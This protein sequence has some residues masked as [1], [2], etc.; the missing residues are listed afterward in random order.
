MAMMPAVAPAADPPAAVGIGANAALPGDG[1]DDDA[2]S[3][4]E[5]FL[6]TFMLSMHERIDSAEQRSSLR[7]LLTKG[8]RDGAPVSP[9]AAAS[10]KEQQNEL[11]ETFGELDEN[12]TPAVYCECASEHDLTIHC[13]WYRNS[14]G[15][16]MC[17]KAGCPT[18]T[19]L[20]QMS[21]AEVLAGKPFS[22][23]DVAEFLNNP[24]AFA[25]IKNHVDSFKS[26]AS[27]AGKK[28]F[29][30][31]DPVLFKAGVEASARGFANGNGESFTA[32]AR[33][34]LL[35]GKLANKF[36][37]R[38]IAARDV[39]YFYLCPEQI[40]ELVEHV[41]SVSGFAVELLLE[42]FGDS[43]IAI[44]FSD[45]NTVAHMLFLD[46]SAAS[47]VFGQKGRHGELAGEQWW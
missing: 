10:A 17:S 9:G 33:F 39:Y 13:T 15:K 43:E 12:P 38:E 7:A 8:G 26:C 2:I 41:A 30:E 20:M 46:W 4:S 42:G 47:H 5:S 36:W 28:G 35:E 32:A 6:A 21:R 23:D 45:E 29:Q 34:H 24:G 44:A 14:D 18:A 3:S 16:M 1:D 31:I 11:K 27:D 22:E 19:L 37:F 25:K 40:Q